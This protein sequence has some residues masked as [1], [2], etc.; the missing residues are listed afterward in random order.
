[1]VFLSIPALQ[2]KKLNGKKYTEEFS[3]GLKLPRFEKIMYENNWLGNLD[4]FFRNFREKLVSQ[5]VD[6]HSIINVRGDHF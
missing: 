3:V 6:I 5:N 2:I 1:M 4:Q